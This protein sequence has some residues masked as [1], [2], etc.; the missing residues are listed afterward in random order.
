M[1][2]LVKRL[3]LMSWLL[4]WLGPQWDVKLSRLRK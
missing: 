4:R 1:Y 3:P 2:R